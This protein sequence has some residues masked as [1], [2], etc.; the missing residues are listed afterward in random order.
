MTISQISF[1]SLRRKNDDYD[2]AKFYNV[3][4]NDLVQTKQKYIK[5]KDIFVPKKKKSKVKTGIITA[6]SL[7]LSSFLG[8]NIIGAS[9]TNTNKYNTTNYN[10]KVIKSQTLPT[11]NTTFP[12]TNSINIYGTKDYIITDTQQ[13]KTADCWLLS[14]INSINETNKGKEFFA[15]ILEYNGCENKVHLHVGDYT[16]SDEELN[17]G[18]IN[19]SK[20]DDD[21]LLIELAVEKA[22]T[23]YNAGTLKLPNA[24]IT[25]Q[26]GGAGT[27]S[28]LNMGSQDAA[29]YI[30]TGLSAEYM[31][32]ESNIEKID[33]YFKLFETTE[34]ENISLTASIETDDTAYTNPKTGQTYFLRGHHAYCIKGIKDGYLTLTN[35]ENSNIEI[36]MDTDS[37]KDIFSS[38][39]YANIS[40]I[41]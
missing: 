12:T 3:Q 22:L 10:D 7:G 40:N 37:F 33:N 6:I 13:G 18:R 11:E 41:A 38:V 5:Q 36:E 2:F 26:L 35:P 16:I 20:G 8:L 4:S 21:V 9:E 28:T 27:F 32:I 25:Q 17:R 14:T 30:L 19:N 24:V 15:D 31:P 34:K 1:G 23:D 39:T 29:I